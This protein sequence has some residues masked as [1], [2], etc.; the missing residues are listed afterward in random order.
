[1]KKR[2]I[3]LF[4]FVMIFGGTA[5]AG[6]ESLTVPVTKFTAADTTNNIP[7]GWKLETKKGKPSLAVKKEEGLLF[8]HLNSAGDSSFGLQKEIKVDVKKYPILC[9]RWKA[10]KLPAGGDVRKSS[11]DDQ[12]IQLYVAFK[13]TGFPSTTNTP[14]IGYIWDAEA[15]KGWSGRSAQI[16]ADKVRY[17]VLRNRTD[18]TG[19]WYT[20]RRNLYQDYKKL[21]G[22]IKGG[23]PQGLTT[24]VQIYINS[25]HTKSPAESLIGEIYFSADPNDI[26]L[27][28]AAKSGKPAQDLNVSTTKPPPAPKAPSGQK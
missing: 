14:V 28:E 5:Y 12:A 23:E 7:A 10:N 26:A 1:M 21:F 4:C 6:P 8:L 25:Q 15:P 2:L 24:G 11:T 18:Q 9:W 20:E 16:G 19:Q 17:I 13:P 22:D 27:A 3:C